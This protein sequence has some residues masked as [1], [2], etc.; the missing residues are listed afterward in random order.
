MGCVKRSRD[1]H[2]DQADIS[3]AQ[4]FEAAYRLLYSPVC[5]YVLRRVSSPEEAAEAV[6]ETFLTLWRRFDDAP[7][8]DAIRPWTY[9]IA[10]RVIANYLRGER[11]R[12]ALT[13]RLANDFARVSGAFP[14]P[15]DAI[16]A[17]SHLQD[18][19]AVLSE[20]DREVLS[21]TA[22]EG[23]TADE[24]A[25]A[26]GVRSGAARLRLHRARRRLRSA[27]DEQ[28]VRK[29]DNVAGQV[30]EQRDTT[31][32]SRIAEGAS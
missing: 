22:W 7:T 6:A 2:A 30:S 26:L 24:V 12:D 5:G 1:S 28:Q 11:R 14:D 18:A 13:E 10:R 9:G 21:L 4:R 25:V 16:V 31:S 27:L 32:H 8:G 17:R 15:A 3:R 20:A 19:M 29:Q 23:L